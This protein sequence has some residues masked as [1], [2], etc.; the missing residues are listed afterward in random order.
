MSAAHPM[1]LAA[2]KPRLLLVLE[3]GMLLRWCLVHHLARWFDV[4]LAASWREAE[5]MLE[6]NGARV[7]ICSDGLSEVEDGG[8]PIPARLATDRFERVVVLTS[9]SRYLRPG[10]VA[11]EKPFDL[12]ELRDSL[13]VGQ[14]GA[15]VAS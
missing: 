8:D 5:R 10:A 11:L 15:R 6:D 13:G 1:T 3:P 14:D 7:L 12:E 9:G 2:R 4:R